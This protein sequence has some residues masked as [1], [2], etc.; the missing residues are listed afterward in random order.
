M[1]TSVLRQSK[2]IRRVN[3]V[4]LIGFTNGKALYSPNEFEV[5]NF[6]TFKLL[7]YEKI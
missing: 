4:R 3:F 7:I 6:I 1:M 5:L 2:P